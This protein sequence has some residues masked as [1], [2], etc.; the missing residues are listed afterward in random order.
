VSRC[1]IDL[2]GR[3]LETL[4]S[5]SET[6]IMRINFWEGPRGSVVGWGTA[7]QAGGSWVRV[8]M[9]SLCSFPFTLSF[10][11]HYGPEVDSASNRNE[12]QEYFWRSKGRRA[13]KAD[14]LT[15]ICEPRP[16]TP[17][18]AFL[19][20]YKDSLPYFIFLELFE[21]IVWLVELTTIDCEFYWRVVNPNAQ[22]R[23]YCA[24]FHKRED[25][26]W[27][28]ELVNVSVRLEF[29]YASTFPYKSLA[30]DALQCGNYPSLWIPDDETN[31]IYPTT[32]R[33]PSK[34]FGINLERICKLVAWK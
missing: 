8:P 32:V 12:Y 5:N 10:Q 23:T 22:P 1:G 31:N 27:L 26:S 9:R 6:K 3:G 13:R 7:L 16:L 21:R 17:P 30:T 15:D 2:F 18:W 33:R 34:S 11:P 28:S 29:Y 19:V 4:R 24:G 25:I 14:N 20:C